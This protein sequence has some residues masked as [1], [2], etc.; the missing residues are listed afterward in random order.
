MSRLTRNLLFNILGQGLVLAL[1]LIAVKFI[2]KQ[3]GDD[4]FGIIYF[5][6]TLATVVAAG[7]ELGILGTTSREV[8]L[9]FDSEPRYVAMLIQTASLLYWTFGL[10]IVAGIFLLAPFLVERWINLKT[11]DPGTA[12]TMI[13]ILGISTMLV[14][15]RSLY[16]SLFRG[17]QR[18]GINNVIDVSATVA[19]QVGIVVLLRAGSGPFTVAWWIS[20]TMVASILTYLLFAGRMFGWAALVPRFHAGVIQRN[21]GYGSLMMANSMLSLVFTQADKVV[22][23]K[24]L[25][26]AEFG[27]YSFASATIGRATFVAAAIGQAAFPSFATLWAAEDRAALLNQFRKLQDLVCFSTLPMF[28]AICFGA[29]PVYTYLFNAGVSDRLILPTV[30]LALGFYLNSVLNTPFMLS[31]AIGKPEI[32]VR[33]NVL[34]LFIVLPVTVVL[35]VGLGILGAAMSWVFYN[36]F[37]YAYIVPRIC[38]G[39]DVRAWTWYQHVLKAG[40]L[41]L[42]AY[43]SAFVLISVLASYSLIALALAYLAGSAL[44]AAGAYPL[45]GADL[46]D[47]LMRLPRTMSVRKAGTP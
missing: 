10:V 42:A 47:T 27:F 22:V 23:S 14:L 4:I 21:R 16:T 33:A 7:L 20:A 13:R 5:N 45:I 2:F 34:A 44:F 39:L 46:R 26:I 25:P 35:I 17:R 19:Q 38:R 9:H 37:A 15:P 31:M 12:E 24:L 8:A 6:I 11:T 3:L 41:G 30:L 40:G 28:A 43:G 18:M 29:R 1:S 32:I 36:L